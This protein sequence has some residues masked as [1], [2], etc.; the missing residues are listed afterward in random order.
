MINGV[1]W[2][3][4]TVYGWFI[5]EVDDLPVRFDMQR[6]INDIKENRQGAL[7]KLLDIYGSALLGYIRSKNLLNDSDS[8]DIYQD[9]VICIW[10]GIMEY[11]PS[12]GPLL[13]YLLHIADGAVDSYY[14]DASAEGEGSENDGYE[15]YDNDDY[16]DEEEPEDT[17]AA[18]KKAADREYVKYTELVPWLKG[19]PD[20]TILNSQFLYEKYILLLKTLMGDVEPAHMALV[21]AVA[22][23][24]AGRTANV[25][26]LDVND[27]MD[28]TLFELLLVFKRE[29][30]MLSRIPDSE[31]D[32]EI[33]LMF[34]KLDEL[35]EDGSKLGSKKLGELL[36][37]EHDQ[38]EG[39]NPANR[40]VKR[41]I[42]EFIDKNFL[43]IFKV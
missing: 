43:E 37:A 8:E 29:Y 19:K 5:L 15:Y 36:A 14:S 35:A 18:V 27:L 13:P 22:K 24:A 32:E 20:Y 2:F 9:A 39:C 38:S 25:K 4:I 10:S 12:K 34:N 41:S 21:Y 40:I 7:D 16:R 3:K 1:Y 26:E 42:H 17:K 28:R 11:E 33:M 30:S 31:T 6:L 23:L